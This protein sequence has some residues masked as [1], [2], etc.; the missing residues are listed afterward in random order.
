MEM[1]GSIGILV[2]GYGWK[3]WTDTQ[4]SGRLR[5]G[6]LVGCVLC[7]IAGSTVLVMAKELTAV[8]LGATHFVALLGI[9]A[10]FF[11]G[12]LA[13]TV[14]N[15]IDHD[16]LQDY[17]PV[18]KFLFWYRNV[19]GLVGNALMGLILV[20]VCVTMGVTT[21]VSAEEKLFMAKQ[22]ELEQ[23]MKAE[24][25]GASDHESVHVGRHHH[26]HHHSAK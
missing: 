23:Q 8:P 5:I 26:H 1:I 16:F 7:V 25:A 17:G 11:F 12:G 21:K 22:A 20:A 18:R 19:A 24:N 2:G 13:I 14:T 9:A 4:R 6:V 3:L 10:A 15:V